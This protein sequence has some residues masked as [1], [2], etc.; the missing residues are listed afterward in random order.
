M[1][2]TETQDIA[3]KIAGRLGFWVAIFKRLYPL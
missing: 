2:T 1:N 3:R